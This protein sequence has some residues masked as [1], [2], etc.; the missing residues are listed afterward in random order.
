MDAQQSVQ[1]LDV[2]Y[3]MRMMRDEL[4]S[5][6]PRCRLFVDLSPSGLRRTRVPPKLS[7]QKISRSLRPKVY[8]CS[9]R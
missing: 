2:L 8:E 7:V 5:H 9:R 6:A 3:G 1:I 4:G